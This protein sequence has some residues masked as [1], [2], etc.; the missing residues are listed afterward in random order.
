MFGAEALH[1]GAQTR[2]AT[3]TAKGEVVCLRL[4]KQDFDKYWHGRGEESIITMFA[5]LDAD[6]SEGIGREELEIHLLTRAKGLFFDRA[7]TNK[8]VETLMAALDDDG[9]GNVT[10]EELKRNACKLPRTDAERFGETSAP[11]PPDRPAARS[12]QPGTQTSWTEPEPEPEPWERSEELAA[13][14]PQPGQPRAPPP[15]WPRPEQ[16]MRISTATTENPL[17][18]WDALRAHRQNNHREAIMRRAASLIATNTPA[19]QAPPATPSWDETA[20]SRH[21]S[22]GMKPLFPVQRPPP[23]SPPQGRPQGRPQET[24]D[25]ILRLQ[26][27]SRRRQQQS[28]R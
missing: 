2:T 9:D 21:A 16:S 20:A 8:L 15:A 1:E 6:Q 12:A 17:H 18:G 11:K 19:T 4:A 3:A 14:S 5:Q 24:Q 23:P 13:D 22:L 27:L 7:T 25:A 26:E 28:S 10:L